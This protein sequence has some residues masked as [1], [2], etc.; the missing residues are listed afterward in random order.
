MFSSYH[1]NTFISEVE[2]LVID[3]LSYTQAL[4]VMWTLVYFFMSF[5]ERMEGKKWILN[6]VVVWNVE[7]LLKLSDLPHSVDEKERRNHKQEERKC[8]TKGDRWKKEVGEEEE[9]ETEVG[10]YVSQTRD[11]NIWFVNLHDRWRK[12]QKPQ[13]GS[14]A[15]V[16]QWWSEHW[17]VC[18]HKHPRSCRKEA[19]VEP[20]RPSV[21]LDKHN[22]FF[23]LDFC[24]V[25]IW[26]LRT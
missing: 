23:F 8:M 3:Y 24:Y 20:G 17:T 15:S 19:A 12:K 2:Y 16:R 22:G 10:A 11:F 9:E 25:Y 7:K 26:C 21:T 1:S 18:L 5:F 14:R 13:N 6:F 4:T